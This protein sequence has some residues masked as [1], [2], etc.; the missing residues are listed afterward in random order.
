[1]RDAQTVDDADVMVPDGDVTPVR[2]TTARN[3]DAA[4][5]ARNADAATTARDADAATTVQDG[6]VEEDTAAPFELDNDCVLF[7][8]SSEGWE[9]S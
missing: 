9:S 6:T 5:T 7:E 4:T 1:M 8:N 2:A 3:A